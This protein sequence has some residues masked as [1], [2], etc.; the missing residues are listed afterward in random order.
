MR[1]M[2]YGP[3]RATQMP[4]K[5]GSEIFG[6]IGSRISAMDAPIEFNNA[7]SSI[8]TVEVNE[9]HHRTIIL[10]Y[11]QYATEPDIVS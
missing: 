9:I 1:F 8:A 6:K 10:K 4:Q 2:A 7:V 5:F 3:I 11:L